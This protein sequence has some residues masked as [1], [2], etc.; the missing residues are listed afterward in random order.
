MTTK[1]NGQWC[2]LRIHTS[3]KS[4]VSNRDNSNSKSQKGGFL[5][6]TTICAPSATWKSR[7][8]IPI[9]PESFIIAFSTESEFPGDASKGHFFYYTMCQC[10]SCRM[11][12][13]DFFFLPHVSSARD[14]NPEAEKP[15]DY[16]WWTGGAQICRSVHIDMH[17][18]GAGRS[19][20]IREICYQ[21]LF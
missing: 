2:V 9:P 1:T 21:G 13:S 11:R 8:I 19:A 14:G 10:D 18:A 15:E 16:V 5:R 3:R 12:M 7:D 6:P 17:D 20:R 4:N